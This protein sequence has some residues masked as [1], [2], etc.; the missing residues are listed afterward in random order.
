MQVSGMHMD[1]GVEMETMLEHLMQPTYMV[2][3][4]QPS[5]DEMAS[6]YVVQEVFSIVDELVVVL[7]SML[8][9][10]EGN[11]NNE[12]PTN[13]KEIPTKND[14][15]TGVDVDGMQEAC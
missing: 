1:Q 6:I 11:A 2:N 7:E 3:Q 14:E 4:K 9:I 12:P 10:F 13:T 15:D 5:V 8:G